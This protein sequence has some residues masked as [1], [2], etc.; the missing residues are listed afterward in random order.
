MIY[1]ICNPIAGNGRSKK[2]GL[3]IK[4]ILDDKGLPCRLLLTESPGH[5]TFLAGAARQAGASMVLSIGGDGTAFEVAQGLLGGDCTLGIIPGGTGNDFIK[6]IGV[7]LD[8]LQALEYILSHPAVAT[9]AGEVNGRMF[10]NEIGTGFDVSVLDFAAK[11]KKY[12]RGLLPYFLGVVKTLFRFRAMSITYSIDGGESVTKDAFVV[13][14]ANG[15]FIGGGIPI[16]PLAKADDGLLDVVVVGKV[17]KRDL[18]SRL[19]GLMQG[20]ILSFPETDCIRAA[21]FTCT[22]PWGRLN[23][24]GEILDET[25]VSVRILPKALMIHR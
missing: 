18:I 19:M 8:P 17:R 15:G 13:A 1:A 20:N 10:I 7:P 16:A 24:D 21:S 6:T 2:I 25:S 22:V 14:A 11:A 12:C 5:A 9:D 3:Q 4:Q 23:V